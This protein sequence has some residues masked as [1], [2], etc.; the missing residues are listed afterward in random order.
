MGT[1]ENQ[2]LIL[3]S[4]GDTRDR[5]GERRRVMQIEIKEEDGW[6][7]GQ[8]QNGLRACSLK[9][10]CLLLDPSS[11]SFPSVDRMWS[12]IL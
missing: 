8:K 10:N 3:D 7:E 5:K 4:C 12:D 2:E 6:R 9:F 11:L 1:E